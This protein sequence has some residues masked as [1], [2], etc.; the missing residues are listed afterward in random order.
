MDLQSP[1]PE[2]G[3]VKEILLGQNEKR[4]V[5]TIGALTSDI[6]LRL[7][8]IEDPHVEITVQKEKGLEE[9]IIT[10]RPLAKK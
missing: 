6:A 7:K 9:Y 3:S 1:P 10:I 4:K 8:G 2:E 5:I